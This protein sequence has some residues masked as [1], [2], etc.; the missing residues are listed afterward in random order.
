[1]LIYS[2]VKV[3]Y[4][5]LFLAGWKGTGPCME[6]V[7][8]PSGTKKSTAQQRMSVQCVVLVLCARNRHDGWLITGCGSDDGTPLARLCCLCLMQALTAT[9]DR[10]CAFLCCCFFFFYLWRRTSR[11][12]CSVWKQSRDH[13]QLL[14]PLVLDAH[15]A[16][17]PDVS[18][19]MGRRDPF[20][21]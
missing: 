17:V 13:P 4:L 2:L 5:H 19:R 7:L 20:C 3:L 16:M 8:C 11:A 10:I 14:S 6:I 9:R 15:V 12:F 21:L 18:S 1:M